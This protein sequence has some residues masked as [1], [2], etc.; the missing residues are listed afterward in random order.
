MISV[1]I[2]GPPSVEMDGIEVAFP[3]KKVEGV[4][5]YLCVHKTT[6]R[7]ALIHTF[8]GDTAEGAGRK[9]LREALYRIKQIFG[10]SFIVTCG[11][12]VVGINPDTPLTLDWDS[13]SPGILLST[14]HHK[15]FS[16]F[17]IKNS[18]EFDQ[19]VEELQEQF[20][21]SYLAAAAHQMLHSPLCLEEHALCYRAALLRHDP[22]NE[23]AYCTAIEKLMGAQLWGLAV[24][25]YQDL[26]QSLKKELDVAPVPKTQALWKSALV[27][28]QKPPVLSHEPP[29]SALMTTLERF[30]HHLPYRSL[31][32]VGESGSDFSSLMAQVSS[33]PLPLLP[34]CASATR[35]EQGFDLVVWLALFE[36]ITS[37]VEEGG[38]AM[39]APCY[40]RLHT[41]LRSSEITT[42]N[43]ISYHVISHEIL[44]LFGWLSSRYRVV[45]VIDQLHW[46][47]GMSVALLCRTLLELPL[48]LVTSFQHSH[49]GAILQ[50]FAPLFERD[51]L[52]LLPLTSDVL[53]PFL[54]D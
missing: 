12:F 22:Y 27:E 35:N 34:L 5:Y 50:K 28:G 8:W 53:S 39:D 26:A 20:R 42:L 9:N 43:S 14:P 13:L 46:M 36:S 7:Q 11:N 2:L 49:Q 4:F 44:S 10:A 37:L 23:T 1:T 38:I 16:H 40:T 6:T 45:L 15:V 47:D 32:F 25:F 51:T 54:K 30:S 18:Y 33:S 48:L 17:Y 41:L 29:C 21:Q 52:E 24:S 31:A 3:Y 19:W